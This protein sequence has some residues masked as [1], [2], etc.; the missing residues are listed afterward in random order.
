[1]AQTMFMGIIVL[2]WLGYTGF[3]IA[4]GLPAAWVDWEKPFFHTGVIE[5]SER[6]Q[7]LILPALLAVWIGVSWYRKSMIGEA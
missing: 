1:M 3:A 4:R 2:A 5:E 7:A 6:L